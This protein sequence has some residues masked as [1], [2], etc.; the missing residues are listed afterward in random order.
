MQESLRERRRRL[1][2]EAR[3]QAMTRLK[4]SGTP[5]V[6]RLAEVEMSTGLTRA[7]LYEAIKSGTFPP[8]VQLSE[9]AVGWLESEIA[10][11]L[12]QRIAARDKRRETR[13]ESTSQA[14]S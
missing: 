5:R 11:W 4:A 12:T 13:A 6:L 3:Q 10:T 7:T 9:R 1:K 8:P 2:V 14:A